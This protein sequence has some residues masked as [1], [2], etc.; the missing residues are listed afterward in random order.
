MAIQMNGSAD[1]S[2]FPALSL[3]V[4]AYVAQAISVASG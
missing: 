2:L 1:P 4:K 3:A